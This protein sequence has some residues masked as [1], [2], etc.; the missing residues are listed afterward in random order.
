MKKIISI[1]LALL[2]LAGLCACGGSTSGNTAAN[3]AEAEPAAQEMEGAEE[4]ASTATAN[5]A[6]A[7]RVFV[8][9]A[10]GN[11]VSGVTVQFCD[12]KTCVLGETDDTGCAVFEADEGKYTAHILKAPAGF[13]FPEEEFALLEAYSDVT[14]GLEG[15]AEAVVKEL[16]PYDAS[17]YGFRYVYP[18]NYQN[19]KGKLFWSVPY[20]SAT[21]AQFALWYATVPKGEEDAFAESLEAGTEE[22]RY[23]PKAI[24]DFGGVNLF[25]IFA[26]YDD[27]YSAEQIKKSF[28]GKVE[29]PQGMPEDS[30]FT[31]YSYLNTMVL[32]ND[33]I[34]VLTRPELYNSSGETVEGG[35]ANWVDEDYQ[36]EVRALMEDT[37]VFASGIDETE[38]IL[39][40]QVG[41]R[42]EFET[43]DL[44][45]N[46][47][48]SGELFSGHKVTMINIWATWCGPCRSELPDLDKLNKQFGEKDCQIIG[49]CLDAGEEGMAETAKQILEKAG[50]TYPNLV[51]TDDMDWAQICSA[52]PTSYFVDENGTVLLETVVGADLN[53][54]SRRID[55]ALTMID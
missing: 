55:K 28:S 31:S 38:W 17:R 6:G 29:V 15:E 35:V 10:E 25:D 36:E 39:P 12:D 9:D 18:E 44:D 24:E 46:T 22:G 3:A 30:Y 54:Y 11:P 45:G 34:L 13:T 23:Q 48:T 52:I 16:E 5:D 37:E 2:M 20:S 32:N 41:S 40:G 50:A 47:V 49:I 33:W 14:I 27:E 21:F 8:V 1:L 4:T 53:K 51:G 7:Y 26:L 19:L 42:I 43:V